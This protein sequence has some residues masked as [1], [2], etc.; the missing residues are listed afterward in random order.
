MYVFVLNSLLSE[1]PQNHVGDYEISKNCKFMKHWSENDIYKI[2]I[3]YKIFY[4][5]L[6]EWT[7]Q[8][9]KDWELLEPVDG[10]HSNQVQ[11]IVYACRIFLMTLEII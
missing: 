10:F 1:H 4:A 3:L 8:G 7:K 11:W 2:Y 6:E 9:G 5:V